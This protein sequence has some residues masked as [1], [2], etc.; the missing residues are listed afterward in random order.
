MNKNWWS[1]W[2]RIAV[3]G[4]WPSQEEWHILNKIKRVGIKYNEKEL[5]LNQKLFYVIHE[6]KTIIYHTNYHAFP[7]IHCEH[8]RSLPF[9]V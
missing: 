4:D 1:E 9:Q 2:T 3:S 5:H 8:V 7:I 6:S